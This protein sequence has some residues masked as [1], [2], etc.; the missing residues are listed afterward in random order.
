MCLLLRKLAD[1]QFTLTFPSKCPGEL[2]DGVVL[3]CFRTVNALSAL[4]A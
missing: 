1:A 3:L 2:L 4:I